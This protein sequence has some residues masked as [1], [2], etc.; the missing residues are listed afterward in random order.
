[1]SRAHLLVAFALLSLL[2]CGSTSPPQ[3]APVVQTPNPEIADYHALRDWLDLQQ[4]VSVMS[5]EQVVDELVEV[6]E[7]DDPTAWFYVALLNQQLNSYDSWVLARDALQLLTDSEGLT[8][9]QRQL[10]EIFVRY[11]QKRIN[12]HLAY[13]DAS[14]EQAAVEQQL[15]EAREQNTV[16]EQKIQAITDLETTISTR[17]EQ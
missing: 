6:G 1:M 16:L 11:N 14:E 17:K 5:E 13:Q 12:W 10:V 7:P 4:A 8:G 15:S 3:P 2:G 9:G